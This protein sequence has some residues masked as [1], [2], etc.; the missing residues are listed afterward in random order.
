M[1]KIEYFIISSFFLFNEF[2]LLIEKKHKNKMPK[3]D[4]YVKNSG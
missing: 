2:H 3:R 4:L 1:T